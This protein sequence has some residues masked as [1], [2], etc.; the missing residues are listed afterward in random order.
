MTTLPDRPNTALLVIDVQNGV[1]AGARPRRG[2]REHQH[3]GRQGPHR[4]CARR[5]G[6]ALRRRSSASSES[7]STCRSW[8]V[9][10][11]SPS[12]HKRYGDSFEDTD[13]EDLLAERG[14]GRLVVTG[15]QTDACV[16]STIHGASSA[17]T[18]SPW[19][20]T[21]IPPR[22]SPWTGAP[23]PDQVV[24]HTNLYWQ[25]RAS[26]RAPRRHGR[27][28]RGQLRVRRRRR[29]LTSPDVDGGES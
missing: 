26:H 12:C 23:P 17:A 6:A 8:C 18:T 2:D 9:A 11:P 1:M 3:P 16:R 15:A 5:L 28:R 25:E 27:H 29:R 7:G 24:S 19:S 14:V 22:T 20:V 10:P 21:H 13:L 4:G